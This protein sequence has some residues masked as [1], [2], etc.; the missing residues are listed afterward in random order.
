MVDEDFF[1]LFKVTCG[2]QLS[3]ISGLDCTK[4]NYFGVFC[5][6][7]SRNFVFYRATKFVMFRKRDVIKDTYDKTN[8]TIFRQIVPNFVN[9]TFK[10]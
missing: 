8:D 5:D 7:I 2:S 10:E 6:S 9:R 1:F 4:P 3:T